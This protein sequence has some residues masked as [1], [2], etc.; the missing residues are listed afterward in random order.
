MPDTAVGGVG[1]GGSGRGAGGTG[2]A[3][4]PS[5]VRAAINCFSSTRTRAHTTPIAATF[6]SPPFD[7]T[8]R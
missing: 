6:V 4:A 8:I 2:I 7:S 3:T 1:L 5:S